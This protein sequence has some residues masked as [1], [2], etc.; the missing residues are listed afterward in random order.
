MYDTVL[1]IVNLP[2]IEI[3]KVGAEY[4]ETAGSASQPY[5]GGGDGMIG[6][7][8]PIVTVSVIVK[9]GKET[10]QCAAEKMKGDV[11]VDERFG[12]LERRCKADSGS[13]SN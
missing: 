13:N 8:R 2:T 3:V 11:R 10:V 9:D 5:Q 1:R 6:T 7:S 12:R 4:D